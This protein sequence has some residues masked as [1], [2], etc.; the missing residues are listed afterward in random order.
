MHVI[1]RLISLVLSLNSFLLFII[2]FLFSILPSEDET[3]SKL[4]L[5]LFVLFLGIVSAYLALW[6]WPKKISIKQV[7]HAF[8][9]LLTKPLE[10][11]KDLEKP[12][13]L[14]QKGKEPSKLEIITAW[15]IIVLVVG[16]VYN[17]SGSDDEP[18]EASTDQLSEQQEQNAPAP[19][20]KINYIALAAM[21]V[22]DEV[23][24][25]DTV[26]DVAGF[27]SSSGS[28]CHDYDN[29][30]SKSNCLKGR[31]LILSYKK[32]YPKVFNLCNQHH[33]GTSFL[34]TCLLS[35]VNDKHWISS[36][37]LTSGQNLAIRGCLK[38][39]GPNYEPVDNCFKKMMQ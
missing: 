16:I 27:T 20:K 33:S 9:G 31:E 29:E 36:N 2:A 34:A 35:W 4:E 6:I 19:R 32:T 1:R 12:S 38:R 11:R 25:Q 26:D 8:L 22:P 15:V 37:K 10:P 39:E 28:T 18:N 7:L 23:L 13:K 24:L 17:C 30:E 5:G 21:D 14:S 3:V